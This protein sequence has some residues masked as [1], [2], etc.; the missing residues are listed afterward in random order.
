MTLVLQYFPT[1]T[2]P[3][4]LAAQVKALTPSPGLQPHAGI[5]FLAEPPPPAVA[6]GAP[7]WLQPDSSSGTPPHKGRG[8]PN[9]HKPTQNPSLHSADNKSHINKLPVKET[10]L[11]LLIMAGN[12]SPCSNT[13][14]ASALLAPY[15]SGI[16]FYIPQQYVAISRG[17]T[18]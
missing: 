18:N 16:Y 9:R 10:K 13:G 7:L 15:H 4:S 2:I 11:L 14:A 6:G 17:N 12:F 5:T 3:R 1:Q 8:E